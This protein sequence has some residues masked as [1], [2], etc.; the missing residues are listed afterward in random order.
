[1]ASKSAALLVK[2]IVCNGVTCTHIRFYE[3]ANSFFIEA[4]HEEYFFMKE[5][6]KLCIFNFA[7]LIKSMEM[8]DLLSFHVTTL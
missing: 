4:A 1:M 8:F 7:T 6:L 2:V 5:I 3:N